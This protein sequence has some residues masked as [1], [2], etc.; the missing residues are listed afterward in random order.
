MRLPFAL[1]LGIAL[2]ACSSSNA[3]NSKT[4]L[5]D[6]GGIGDIRVATDDLICRPQVGSICK[7]S[8]CKSSQHPTFWSEWQAASK[9]Y[10]RCDAKGCDA[11]A[12]T[13]HDSG[14]FTNMSI[15]DHGLMTR[16]AQDG[17]FMELATQGKVAYIYHGTC[18]KVE[19][20]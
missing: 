20:R 3:E 10:K 11:Y 18:T 14:V 1:I 7:K 9:I 12:A 15:A 19:Q 4:T 8:G 2:A 13:L 17:S 6:Y 16:V 5:E